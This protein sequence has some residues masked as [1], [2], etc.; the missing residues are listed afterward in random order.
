MWT[1]GFMALPH[2]LRTQ[3]PGAGLFALLLWALLQLPSP[4]SSIPFHP[5]HPCSSEFDRGCTETLLERKQLSSH[6]P[7]QPSTWA[8]SGNTRLLKRQQHGV[9]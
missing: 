1:E 2:G 7:G 6:P 8:S 5:R 9:L 4:P 3:S